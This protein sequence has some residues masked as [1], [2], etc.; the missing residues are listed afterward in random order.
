M[1]KFTDTEKPERPQYVGCTFYSLSDTHCMRARNGEL[2]IDGTVGTR[3]ITLHLTFPAVGG[4][5]LRLS[6]A[7]EHSGYFF[8]PEHEA[9]CRTEGSKT[10]SY[11]CADNAVLR[12]RTETDGF[13]IELT[14]STGERCLRLESEQ[15]TF[16]LE[17]ETGRILQM[18]LAFSLQCG[19]AIYNGAERYSGVDLVGTTVDAYN[20]DAAYHG[21]AYEDLE[22]RP[23]SY[24]NSPLFHSSRGYSVWFNMAYGGMADIGKKDKTRCTYLFEGGDKLDALLF[25]GTIKENLCKYTAITG[26]SGIPEKWVFRYW[27]GG[28]W[29]VWALGDPTYKKGAE[30]LKEVMRGYADMGIRNIGAYFCEGL[31]ESADCNRLLAEDGT[32]MLM[33]F[34]AQEYGKELTATF[35]PGVPYAQLPYAHA[36]DAPETLSVSNFYDFSNPLIE[37]SLTRQ[38]SPYWDYDVRGGMMDFGEMLPFNT[39]CANGLS[40][41]E[42]HNL[43][44]VYYARVMNKIW[45]RRFGNDYVL[46]QRSGFSGTQRYTGNF[47][48]D[49]RSSFRG[50][51]DQVYA[52]ISMGLGGYNIYG[53]DIGGNNGIPEE[54]L[55]MRWYQFATFQP[56]M[57][58]HGGSELHLPWEKGENAR[59]NFPRFYW[60]RENL[61]DTL[62]SAAVMAHETAV[63]IV[64]ALV[65]AYPDD[66]RLYAVKDAYLFCE[67]MLVCP[68]LEMGARTRMVPFPKGR[69]TRLWDGCAVDGGESV[70]VEAPLT[71]IPVFLRDGAVLPLVLSET[72]TLTESMQDHPRVAALLMTRPQA[73]CVRTRYE[74]AEDALRYTFDSVSKTAFTL[75]TDAVCKRSFILL[76]DACV[77][78]VWADGMPLVRTARRQDAIDSEGSF[79]TTADGMTV[80]HLCG[81]FKTL[82]V[83]M[84]E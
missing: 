52:S 75:H 8:V 37:T 1:I 64:Q 40:G 5:R 28:A 61:I 44:S 42:M 77:K 65:Y 51:R 12:V 27:M 36:A 41:L 17:E 83:R 25:T 47:L 11:V 72:L 79:Y 49:Q 66:A 62:Y 18:Q 10:V 53:G 74:T 4:I 70:E 73:S 24:I 67:D 57:R 16:G 45:S 71:E 55:Y 22:D 60:L 31:F 54:E 6:T 21:T 33:W 76:Y 48:G 56:L 35:L 78:E 2:E 32:R 9:V 80:L 84:E 14:D 34:G 15:L 23:R 19:E 7:T 38:L 43:V 59:K 68:V 29:W 3:P 58:V 26:T 30:N 82:T 81:G 46:F 20:W 39:V 50:L 69:W 13:F 63:P